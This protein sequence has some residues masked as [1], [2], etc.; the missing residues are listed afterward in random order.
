MAIVKQRRLYWVGLV[1]AMLAL[2]T[3]VASAAS[4]VVSGNSVTCTGGPAASVSIPIPNSFTAPSTVTGTPYP[5]ALAVSGAPAGATVST[6]SLT[7]NGYTSAAPTTGDN[8]AD[9]GILLAD[10]NSKNLQILR[11][12]GNGSSGSGANNV[13][14]VIVDGGSTIPACAG[15]NRGGWMPSSEPTWAPGAYDDSARDLEV[16]P[17]YGVTIGNSASSIGTGTLN[18]VFL[19]EPVNGTWNL[20][21]ADDG[22]GF[23]AGISFSSWSITITYTGATT[24]TTTTLSAATPSNNASGTAY[25]SSPNDG[26]TLTATVTAGATGTVTFQDVS[27]SPVTNLTCSGGNPA[28]LSG[29]TATCVTSFSSE[30]IHSLLASYS[31]NAIYIGSSS[32]ADYVFVQNHATNTGTTYCNA[33]AISNNGASNSALGQGQTGTT[34]YPSVIFVG[35]GSNT[36]IT[37]SV[38]TVSVELN[39]VAASNLSHMLLM[40]PDGSHAFDFWSTITNVGAGSYS[41]ID[42]QPALPSDSPSAGMY[43]PAAYSL[44]N[45]PP[46]DAF[47][48]SAP[49]PAPQLPSSFMVAEPAGTGSF[50]AAFVGAE[51]H[52]AWS[53]YMFNDNGTAAPV[54]GGWCLDI[55]AAIGTATTTTVTQNLTRAGLGQAVTFTATVLGSGGVNKGTVTFTENGSPLT[56]APNSGVAAVSA[57]VAMIATSSLPEGDHTITA[58]YNDSTETYNESIGTTTMRVDKATSTPTLSGS[59][60]SYC[61]SGTVTIPRGT[62]A[63]N[64]LGPAQPNPSNIFVTNLPGKIANVSV[65][66]EGFHLPDGGNILESMLVGPNGASVP[67]AAQTLDF[68]SL[69]GNNDPFGPQNTTFEDS[70]AAVTCST[71]PNAPP[72]TDGPT[73]C[74]ATS[75]TASSFYTLPGGIQH[76]SPAGAFTF[77]TGT[78]TGTGGGVYLDTNPNGT[79][80]LYF[81]QT[82]HTTGGGLSGGWCANFTENPVSVAVEKSHSGNFTQGQQGAQFAI[83][84]TNDGPGATGD[85]DGNHPLTV[86]DVLTAD[87]TAGTLPTG[88]PWNCSAVSKVVTCTS[89]L[90][91]AQGD[92]YPTLTIPVNVSNTAGTGDINQVSVSGAGVTG[93]LSNVDN[94]TI[95]PAAF[96]AIS[97]APMGAFTQGQTAEWDL[98]VSNEAPSGTTNGTVSVT[99]TLPAGYTI[100]NFGSTQF[101]SCTGAGTGAASCSTTQVVAGG[102]SF[103]LIHIIVNV[104]A[105]SATSV[106]NNASAWGGGDLDHTNSSNAATTFSTVTVAQSQFVLTTAANPSN[107]GTVMPTSGG[108]YNSGAVVPIT[109][110]PAS[111]YAFVNWTSS[112]GSVANS[113]SPSTSITMNAAESV[114]ANFAVALTYTPS[115]NFGT[116]Y[117]NSKHKMTGTITNNSGTNV[118]FTSATITLGTADAG[119]YK[120]F[121]YCTGTPLKPGKSCTFAV[122]LTAD[123]VGTLTATLN[124]FDSA[125]TQEVSLTASVIDPIAQFNLKTLSFGSVAVNGSKTLPVQLKNVGLTDL[126]INNVSIMGSNS[127]GLSASSGCPASLTPNSSCMIEVTFAPTAKGA[128]AGSLAVTDNVAAGKSAIPISGTGH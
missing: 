91:V 25:A 18:G 23:G 36:D 124:I 87:F 62:L 45:D 105:N 11:C 127:T 51:A 102:S 30:G 110:S 69:I 72:A 118:T 117:L 34:P 78:L 21:L 35:D 101:W 76:A 53:L 3:G 126:N 104:P 73:S 4:C 39:G 19:G 109:A 22:V 100:A 44:D 26:V 6:V 74:G 27:K 67:A 68:V 108:S 115:L 60:W 9:V 75:Y 81:N 52:G 2:A 83:N 80:S 32:S 96:L 112:P 79:W 121:L 92:S 8:S 95:Q 54:N 107:G 15:G 77:N 64:D 1:A 71:T 123:T 38:S 99:D 43:G 29:G 70:A 40:A 89:D 57:G 49:L 33:G 93:T 48:P 128:R 122:D 106:T 12:A 111:G 47:T 90:A 13:N 120:P 97:K 31:G 125:G 85:P 59:T 65:T 61:N 58:T 46:N 7:L 86:V 14:V 98:T 84:I 55:A 5:S 94:V 10:P 24:P 116:V 41:I 42:R 20:Y 28:T 50:G 16:S 119:A 63:I 88:T 66:L 82:L 113:T 17:N 37:T 56:G 103:S 114:T